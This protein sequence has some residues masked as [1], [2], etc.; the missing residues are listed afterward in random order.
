[1]VDW[2]DNRTFIRPEHALA[3]IHYG[4]DP[5][6]A[7]LEGTSTQGMN[8][9]LEKGFGNPEAPMLL[10]NKGGDLEIKNALLDMNTPRILRHKTSLP[11][12][13]IYSL[14]CRDPKEVIWAVCTINT[15]DTTAKTYYAFSATDTT[16][17]TSKE[18]RRWHYLDIFLRGKLN[19]DFQIWP[20]GTNEFPSSVVVPYL[21]VIERDKKFWDK[22]AAANDFLIEGSRLERELTCYDALTN[23]PNVSG[24]RLM[25]RPENDDGSLVIEADF[26]DPVS[27]DRFKEYK[28]VWGGHTN[29]E[30]DGEEV[31]SHTKNRQGKKLTATVPKQLNYV[32]SGLVKAICEVE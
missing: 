25:S 27:S 31:Y 6:K 3:L 2:Q 29:L 5:D 15:N 24:L 4:F 12:F 20:C 17:H 19:L 28:R 21:P 14:Q 13:G 9:V 11:T 32:A 26:K 22:L 18:E 10:F 7:T 1:M 8:K 16:A 23:N 30:L